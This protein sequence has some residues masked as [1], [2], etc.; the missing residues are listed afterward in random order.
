MSFVYGCLPELTACVGLL[1]LFLAWW[2]DSH[3]C[4]TGCRLAYAWCFLSLLLLKTTGC[5]GVSVSGLFGRSAFT[6]SL[7]L[8][9]SL[10][11]LLVLS[12]LPESALFEVQA[13]LPLAFIGQHLMIMS[14]DAVSF[15]VGLELQNL[16]LLVL[17]GLMSFGGMCWPV[18]AAIKLLLLSAFSSGMLLLGMSSLYSSSG[19]TG[20][21]DIALFFTASGSGGFALWLITSGLVWKIG[22][23]PMHMWLVSVYQSVWTAVS[24]YV[25]TAPKLAAFGFWLH[26]WQPIVFYA[27]DLGLAPFAALSMVT[28]AVNA[29]AQPL[30]KPLLSYSAIGMNGIFFMALDAA[31]TCALWMNLFVYL[32]TMALAWPLLSHL[33]LL[34]LSDKFRALCWALA[35][36]SMAGLPPLVGFL[37]KGMV[38]YAI[39][40]QHSLDSPALL[41]VALFCTGLSAV[42]YLYTLLLSYL[43]L[44][45]GMQN[46]VGASVGGHSEVAIMAV[47]LLALS[48]SSQPALLASALL[49]R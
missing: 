39:G 30:V 12:W 27:G 24:F 37:G 5:Y 3:G 42:Y 38:F 46:L 13:L 22:A 16:C 32:W 49:G 47:G 28:G 21:A 18:E 25:S 35:A 19:F 2:S 29:L 20:W 26:A 11:L 15:V 17:G 34:C 33:N 7:S 8:S 31:E 14:L 48:W 36:V 40:A 4:L 1:S 23:A 41:A 44:G 45:S 9:L 43:G 6:N 10:S